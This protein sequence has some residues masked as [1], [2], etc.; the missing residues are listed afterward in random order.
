MKEITALEKQKIFGK[1]ITGTFV[2]SRNKYPNER[3]DVFDG[4]LSDVLTCSDFLQL[5][6]TPI[7]DISDEHAIEVAKLLDYLP[8]VDDKQ[9][10]DTDIAELKQHLINQ[11]LDWDYYGINVV[12][13]VIDF[14]R[15]HG[16][17]TDCDGY[18]VNDLVAA[19][20]FKLKI[21]EG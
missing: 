2:Y 10:V 12:M 7:S 13:P 17:A 14:L 3:G 9:S 16:Y 6:V 1:Y 15:A 11:A 18:S 19:G 8:Y 4:R 20:I 5:L 21:K